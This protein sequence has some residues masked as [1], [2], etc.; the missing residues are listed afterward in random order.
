MRPRR[1]RGHGF[2]RAQVRSGALL[3]RVLAACA[4]LPT[5]AAEVLHEYFAEAAKRVFQAVAAGILVRSKDGYTLSLGTK[6]ETL[7][8]GILDQA[9]AFASRAVADNRLLNF[10]LSQPTAQGEKLYCGLAQP[11]VTSQSAA[12]FLVVR[13]AIFSPVEVSVFRVLGGLARLALGNAELAGLHSGQQKN[14]NELLDISAEL[15]VTAR[16]DTFLSRFVVRAA[17]FLG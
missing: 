1:K 8:R 15:G 11:L 10:R 3:E 14:L 4:Q 2:P 16:L 13:K 9:Q 5:G 17:E 12:A 6:G 7:D